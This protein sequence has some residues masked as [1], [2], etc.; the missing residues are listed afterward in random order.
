MKR[1]RFLMTNCWLENER[2]AVRIARH[3]RA[4]FLFALW[5]IVLALCSIAVLVYITRP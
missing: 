1:P 2:N 3:N 5:M 4:Q